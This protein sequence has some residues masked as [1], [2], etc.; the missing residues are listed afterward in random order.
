M[1]R[2]SLKQQ[3]IVHFAYR[4][5]F[6][7]PIH[8]A[9]LKDWLGGKTVSLR[10]VE[11]VLSD[12]VKEELLETIDGFSY[13]LYGRAEIFTKH[14][15]NKVLA[16]EIFKKNVWPL[17]LLSFVPMIRY[18]GISGSVAA[19]NATVDVLGDNKGHVDLDIF[20]ITS[21]SCLW[22][23]FFIE[24]CFANLLRLWKGDQHTYCFNY[25]MDESFLEVHNK[26]IFTATEIYN[27]K[28]VFNKGQSFQSMLESNDWV[29]KYYPT[30]TVGKA[31]LR[32]LLF[33]SILYIL[34]YPINTLLYFLFQLARAIKHFSLRPLLEFS[35]RFKAYKPNSLN[36]VCSGNGG[37]E[38]AI[39]MQFSKNLKKHFADYY[40]EDLIQHA[41]PSE[42]TA[43]EIC[44][45]SLTFF[46]KYT[47][48]RI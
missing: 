24:R 6:N 45:E 30:L 33:D 4:D 32:S 27:L 31:P 43:A 40:H 39:K 46:S 2:L 44:Q 36:R 25:A 35:I 48:Q 28:P 12:L 20:M 23:V 13:C 18:V 1:N 29:A 47:Y 34:F 5:V 21:P 16:V 9:E 42:T 17:K 3:I 37:Y 19:G 15:G 7:A 8:L 14:A 26:S 41:F 38:G 22:I 10:E 11:T